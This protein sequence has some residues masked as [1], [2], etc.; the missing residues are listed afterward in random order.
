MESKQVPGKMARKSYNK[1]HLG[2]LSDMPRLEQT[3]S[4]DKE[5]Q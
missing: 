3:F 2:C 1:R 5:E 4:E